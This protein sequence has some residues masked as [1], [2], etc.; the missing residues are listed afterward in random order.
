MCLDWGGWGNTARISA[1]K[2]GLF[3]QL[4]SYSP[5]P[6]L[7][8][9]K[10][11]S[12]TETC[13]SL[14][15]LKS[16]SN[17]QTVK[18]TVKSWKLWTIV[19]LVGNLPRSIPFI[20][21]AEMAMCSFTWGVSVLFTCMVFLTH[22]VWETWKT[23]A[24]I[25]RSLKQKAFPSMQ[26]GVILATSIVSGCPQLLRPAVQVAWSWKQKVALWTEFQPHRLLGCCLW[27][28]FV[29]KFQNVFLEPLPFVVV[30]HFF[31]GPGMGHSL[32]CDSPFATS[33]NVDEI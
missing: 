22:V 10:C 23:M 9:A 32:D 6:Q 17:S 20:T 8:K 1:C 31:I 5:P 27:K 29:Y 14:W 2:Y 12:A 26:V 25:L 33:K 18:C 24:G 7:E 16:V 28:Y 19:L 30:F 4:V 15:Y 3:L 11:H 21:L 13:I